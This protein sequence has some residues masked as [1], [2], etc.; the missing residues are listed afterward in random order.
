MMMEGC[1]S[2]VSL[3]SV[4]MA[5]AVGTAV[6]RTAGKHSAGPL[7]GA[8]GGATSLAPAARLTVSPLG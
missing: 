3:V 2:P 1:G 8:S 4:R 5:R 6:R 7:A